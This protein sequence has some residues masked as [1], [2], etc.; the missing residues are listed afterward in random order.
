MFTAIKGEMHWMRVLAS[1]GLVGATL[2]AGGGIAFLGDLSRSFAEQNELLTRISA[3][4]QVDQGLS[5]SLRLLLDELT[6]HFASEEALLVYRDADLER[7]FFWRLKSGESERLIP[8]NLPLTRADGLLLDDMDAVVC[9]NT[10]SGP[11]SGFGWDRRDGRTL[12]TLPRL[13]LAT[14]Q[15]IGNRS[16]RSVPFD[17]FAKAACRVL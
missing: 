2:A 12:K 1:V 9:W 8:E 17:P 10:L 14:Q 16:L 4:M 3:T 11:G 13:L 15:Q 7:I 6:H 5:E